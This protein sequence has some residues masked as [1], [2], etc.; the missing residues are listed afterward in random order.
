MRTGKSSL[1]AF[2]GYI[3]GQPPVIEKEHKSS[4]S[5]SKEQIQ[6][7][8]GNVLMELIDDKCFFICDSCT[9]GYA[10]KLK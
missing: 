2:V 4:K 1:P 8:T 9:S 6:C 7:L 3:P 5:K 10:R